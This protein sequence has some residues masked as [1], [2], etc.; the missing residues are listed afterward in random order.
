[1]ESLS[2]ELVANVAESLPCPNDLM[3]LRLVSRRY[4]DI[5]APFLFKTL[6]LAGPQQ[7]DHVYTD[8]RTNGSR[9][10]G[11]KKPVEFG[12]LHTA[13]DEILGVSIA[14]HVQTITFDPAYYR[15]GFWEDYL[16]YV[17]EQLEEPIDEA[18]LDYDSDGSDASD[19]DYERA[20]RRAQEERQTRLERELPA[21]NE[22]RAIWDTK[23]AQQAVNEKSVVE[24]LTKL[25][26]S[27]CVLEKIEIMPW[28]FHA[29]MGL[30]LWSGFQ[31]DNLRDEASPSVYFLRIISRAL[32]SANKRLKYLSVSE[33]VPEHLL[34]DE[35][36]R[37]IF[38]GL[39]HLRLAIPKVGMMLEDAPISSTFIQ[40]FRCTAPT[41]QRLEIIGGSKWPQLPERGSHSLMKIL[42]NGNEETPLLFPNLEFLRLGSYILST[43]ALIKFIAAQPKLMKLHFDHIYL[44]T[45]ELGWPSVAL[46]L[47]ANVRAWEVTGNNG[48]FPMNDSGPLVAYNW[49]QSWKPS[50]TPLPTKYGWRM[51]L[52]ENGTSFIRV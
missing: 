29:I 48:H 37:H 20:M 47:P 39:Q 14:R 31:F 38:T 6:R 17:Q 15:E 18:D 21:I 28:E 42:C 50:Q 49:H 2:L 9:Y 51:L 26:E 13:I 24:A 35:A 36:T 25:F 4:A 46:A 8:G 40:L 23:M 10:L 41:L 16:V 34:D 52:G 5:A 7:D 45:P 27:M 44:A 1:M 30:D 22:A 12:C 19:D 33:V 3:S 32:K 43:S 11:W